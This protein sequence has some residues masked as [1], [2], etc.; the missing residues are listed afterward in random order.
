[1]ADLAREFHVSPSAISKILDGTR[2]NGFKRKARP[3]SKEDVDRIK[4]LRGVKTQ[5]ELAKE[6]GVGLTVIWR[7]QHGKSYAHTR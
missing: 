1:M 4:S 7:I 3:F 6:Y 5:G 2:W